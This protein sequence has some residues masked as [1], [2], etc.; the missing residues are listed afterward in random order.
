MI[1]RFTAYG[2]GGHGF[3]DCTDLIFTDAETLLG[4]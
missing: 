4:P 3:E 1:L 2:A